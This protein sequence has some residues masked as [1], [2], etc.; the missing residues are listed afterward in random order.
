[1]AKEMKDEP[2]F[3]RDT[4]REQAVAVPL[5]ERLS[6]IPEEKRWPLNTGLAVVSINS[7]I[8]GLICNS[9]LRRMCM[10]GGKGV[11]LSMVPIAG[12]CALTMQAVWQATVVNPLVQGRLG[13]PLCA[14]L[15]GGLVNFTLG[16]V[17][18]LALAVPINGAMSVMYRT[19]EVPFFTKKATPGQFF[20]F[21][22]SK[23]RYFKV[24]FVTIAIFQTLVGTYLAGK[25]YETIQLLNKVSTEADS[26]SGQQ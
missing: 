26:N 14:E 13:C 7:T 16:A 15:R 17:Y 22:V 11:F 4:I 18:P 24:Q 8:V 25:Q 2:R 10:L 21:W 12:S 20:Q 6:Q 1:M 19:I 9:Y 3:I 23:L 5:T